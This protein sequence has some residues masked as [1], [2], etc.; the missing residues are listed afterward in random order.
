MTYIVRFNNEDQGYHGTLCFYLVDIIYIFILKYRILLRTLI[1]M[2][3]D[4]Q[5]ISIIDPVTGS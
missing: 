2:P 1:F 5:S 4:S 3:Y